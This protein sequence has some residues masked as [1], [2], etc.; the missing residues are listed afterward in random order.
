MYC[1]NATGGK[2]QLSIFVYIAY[3]QFSGW[4]RICF[5]SSIQSEQSLNITKR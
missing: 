5:V 1:L 3:I 2:C 4:T